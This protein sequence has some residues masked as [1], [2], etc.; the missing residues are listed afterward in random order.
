MRAILAG[1]G[2]AA[3]LGGLLWLCAL[4]AVASPARA[5]P[6]F[7]LHDGAL[8]QHHA[9]EKSTEKLAPP[10]PGAVIGEFL[11]VVEG[12]HPVVK[13]MPADWDPHHHDGGHERDPA[14][15]DI[16]VLGRDGQVDRVLAEGAVRAYPS[17][18]GR[19]IALIDADYSV[20]IVEGDSSRL[21]DIPERTV[22]VA[23]SP[24]ERLLC[25]TVYPPD[26][27]F[28]AASR[29]EGPDD[30]LRLINNDLFLYDLEAD[31]GERLTHYTGYDYAGTFSP[32]G[33]EI[34]FISSR[35]GRGAF[36]TLALET[37]EIR[38]ITNLAPGSYD[39][40]VGRSQSIVWLPH[41]NS[42]AYEAQETPELSSIRTVGVDGTNPRNLGIG[43]QP[44]PANGGAAVVFLDETAAP[45]LHLL[46]VQ[47]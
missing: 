43:E 2:W 46:E 35:S 4:A 45:R 27:T 25:L 41:D 5:E 9:A 34:L 36:Y 19:K 37:R 21:L 28:D 11:G 29:A 17:P 30:F 31:T 32:D 23:W 44:R 3:G 6:V 1:R 7:F 8:I 16:A 12:N 33:S 47:P 14:I 18:S 38:Q 40:P 22:L 20:H 42:I 10:A 24:D 39:V 13:L 26:W 15:G